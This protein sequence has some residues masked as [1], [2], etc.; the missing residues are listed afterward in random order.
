M[1]TAVIAM[2]A[3]GCMLAGCS[4]QAGSAGSAGTSPAASAAKA[5]DGSVQ[6]PSRKRSSPLAR[7]S[8]VA[9]SLMTGAAQAAVATQYQG[10]EIVSRWDAGGGTFLVSDIW[11]SPGGQTLT[12][13]MNTGTGVSSQPYWSSD[14][15]GDSPEGVLGVTT[16][17][18]SLLE[19]HYVVG[20]AGSGSAGN[21]SAQVVEAWRDDGSLAARFWLD[22]ATKLPLER[23]VFDSAAHV[24]NQGVFI[25]V[26]IGKS[27]AGA[28]NAAFG[29]GQTADRQTDSWAY[30]I[31]PAK[32]LALRQQGWLVP[33]ALPGGLTLFTGGTART[34]SGLVLDLDYSD[35]LFVVSLFEQRGKLAAKLAGWQRAKVGGRIVY[36]AVPTQRSLTW[37]G[38]GIVYTLIADAP[39][40]SVATVV[41]V[42]PYDKPPGFWKR[43]SRGLSRITSFV[44]PF[45]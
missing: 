19:T 39:A 35:G 28:A 36:A 40:K 12:Q 30:P 7:S 1:L 13:T 15:D 6:R 29:P 16:T 26:Q 10:E 45:H 24:I 18:V 11:H 37:S 14:L 2:G 21:R 43:M 17:L 23:E 42:L 32:L 25:N 9:L 8:P 3:P 44:N 4:S 5:A 22:S 33:T 31:E 41:G 34:T 27:S 20:Y 38:N